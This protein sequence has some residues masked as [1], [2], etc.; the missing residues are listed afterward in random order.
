MLAASPDAFVEC[1]CCGIGVVEFKCPYTARN[2]TIE[3]H[4][5]ANSSFFM[6]AEGNLKTADKYYTQVQFQMLVTG[7]QY[8]DFGVWTLMDFV[9]ERIPRNN[10]MIE[11]LESVCSTFWTRHISPKLLAPDEA[12]PATPDTVENVPPPAAKKLCVL[13][14]KINRLKTVDCAQ[15]SCA[16]HLKCVNLKRVPKTNWYCAT[17]GQ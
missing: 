14:R 15:C 2:S 11:E 10:R 8:A 7:A 16:F 6:D 4:A 13:S 5:R 12:E 3:D 1:D 17:C 9:V